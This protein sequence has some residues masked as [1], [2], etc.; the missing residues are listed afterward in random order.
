MS[1]LNV[2]GALPL[3]KQIR[4]R[5]LEVILNHY[6]YINRAMLC[7]LWGLGEPAVS[8]V[9]ADYKALS[10]DGIIYNHRTRRIEKLSHFEPLFKEN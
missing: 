7:E 10:G 3:P 9:I 8:A 1:E 2:L 4:L 6:G 5:E